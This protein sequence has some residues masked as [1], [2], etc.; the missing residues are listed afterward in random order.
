MTILTFKLSLA[1][2]D[3]AWES[4]YTRHP[5]FD[6]GPEVVCGDLTVVPFPSQR[7]G[8]GVSEEQ[9]LARPLATYGTAVLPFGHFR[10]RLNCFRCLTMLI[11]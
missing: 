5:G 2:V 11:K 7:V 3:L 10:K 1:L 8:G 9:V 4:V 6:E